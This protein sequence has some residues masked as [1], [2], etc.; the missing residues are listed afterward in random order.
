[1][2]VFTNRR[3][4]LELGCPP[5]VDPGLVPVFRIFRP[6][7]FIVFPVQPEHGNFGVLGNLT[8]VLRSGAWIAGPAGVVVRIT[9]GAPGK[10]NAAHQTCWRTAYRGHRGQAANGLACHQPTA[11]VHIGQS[12]GKFNRGQDLF[13]S[14][15]RHGLD[16]AAGTVFRVETAKGFPI[17]YAVRNQHHKTLGHQVA[18]RRLRPVAALAGAPGLHRPAMVENDQRKRPF[19]R[20]AVHRHGQRHG[21]LAAKHVFDRGLGA[22]HLL[23]QVFGQHF[24]RWAGFL[25]LGPHAATQLQRQKEYKKDFHPAPR[26]T[27]G[28]RRTSARQ[29]VR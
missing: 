13:R 18:R 24:G 22:Q 2:P 26:L 1:M 6:P 8:P 23:S 29:S 9:A 15:H 28:T 17:A 25:F 27:C 5:T 14:S 21:L 4:S 20:R 16:A 19:A 12:F 3:E 11:G 10:I 7:V